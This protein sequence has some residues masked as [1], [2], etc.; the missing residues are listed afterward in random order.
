[1]GVKRVALTALLF[2]AAVASWQWM[3]CN[4]V[5]Q[6]NREDFEYPENWVEPELYSDEPPSSEKPESTLLED[7]IAPV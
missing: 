4:Q 3:R 5:W 2:A 7:E 6:A 1:M